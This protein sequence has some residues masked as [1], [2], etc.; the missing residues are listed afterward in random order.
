MSVREGDVPDMASSWALGMRKDPRAFRTGLSGRT[1]EQAVTLGK[2][3]PASCP[4]PSQLSPKMLL[5]GASVVLF[6]QQLLVAKQIPW[7]TMWA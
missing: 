1:T 7:V 4:A 5:E 3:C 2:G 6:L